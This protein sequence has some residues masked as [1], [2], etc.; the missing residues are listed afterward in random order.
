MESQKIKDL[1]RSGNAS[2]GDVS[3]AARAAIIET[4]KKTDYQGD[5]IDAI[6][7][8][9]IDTNNNLNYVNIEVKKQ[10]EQIENIHKNVLDTGA[11]VKKADKTIGVMSRR[12]FCQKILLHILAIL[13]F[14]AIIT[15]FIIKRL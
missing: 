1:L 3:K 7:K 2:R 12:T 13:L 4:H 10:G 9:L 11:S 15:V 8:D 14:V 5:L 6:G